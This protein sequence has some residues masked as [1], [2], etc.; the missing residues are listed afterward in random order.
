[1][2]D[3]S[4]APPRARGARLG[5]LDA[6]RGVA[7]LV[8]VYEHALNPLYPEL[9]EVTG[10]WFDAGMYGVMVFFLVSGYVIPASLERRGSVPEFWIGRLFRL[11]PLWAVVVAAALLLAVTGIDAPHIWLTD[12]PASAILGHL[13]MLQD[14]LNVPN[15]INVLWTLSYEMAFY[16]LVTALYLARVHLRSA[17]IAC[18]F[19]VLAV[20]AGGILP[21]VLLSRGAGATLATT[22][23]VIALAGC[24][25]AGALSSRA[26]LRRAGAVALALVTLGLIAVNGRIP[27]WQSLTILA[28]MFAG[29]ALY[30]AKA[31]QI[32]WPRALALA[33]SVPVAAVAAGGWHSPGFP[34]SWAIA[35][36]AA[37]ATFAAG[38]LLAERRM[39]AVWAW[40]GMVS[41]SVYLLH[42]ILLEI[43]D[44][45]LPDPASIAWPYRLG[46]GVV[47]L[48]V[49]LG[50]S[51]LTYRLVEAPAQRAG[52]RLAAAA[53][54]GG[55][56]PGRPLKDG[57]RV[58]G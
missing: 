5:W 35:V 15:V 17:E 12:R 9:R 24:G 22:L 33:G 27:A 54:S 19:G 39:P 13:T 30:R 8:V 34:W 50:C 58:P 37:W 3:T 28:T 36:V 2:R 38:M 20:A 42:P 4:D 51:A 55:A 1:M 6:L 14:L 52:R 57:G 43:V 41:Y 29:T 7:A 25:L 49:L 48:A 46:L 44:G 56:G 32:G 10:P 53:R 47:V 23:A 31:G 26:A 16:L 45:L 18:G 11:Y 40:L 21:S